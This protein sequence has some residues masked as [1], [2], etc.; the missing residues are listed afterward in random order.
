MAVRQV[1]LV[2]V[3]K[4]QASIVMPV[5]RSRSLASATVTQSLTPS[6]ESALPL[7]P[8]VVQAAPESVPRWPV[9]VA[10]AVE[11]PAPS[12]KP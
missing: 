2:V 3:G 9:P 7:R 1:L 10:S 4:T 6:N 8:A 5:V 11:G 12:S